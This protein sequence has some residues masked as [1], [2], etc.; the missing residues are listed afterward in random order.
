MDDLKLLSR[1]EEDLENEMKIVKA[2]SKDINMNFGSEKC[3]K[4]CLQKKGRVRRKTCIESTFQKD[5]K[6]LDTRKAYK[7]IGTE[8]S[9]DIE[10]KN[11]KENLKKYLRGLRLLLVTELS[12]KNK[13]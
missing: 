2:I 13:I 1:S 6:E 7:Y 10:H 11:E 12:P 8:L 4:I 5:I 9:H 3:A